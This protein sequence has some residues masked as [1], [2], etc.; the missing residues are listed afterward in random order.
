MFDDSTFSSVEDPFFKNIT[1]TVCVTRVSEDEAPEQL[2]GQY[3]LGD[4]EYIGSDNKIH[5]SFID[6][7]YK[8]SSSLDIK[9]VLVRNFA[10]ELTHMY[11]N[12]QRR[13]HGKE[14]MDQVANRNGYS[15]YIHRSE[16]DT[17][18]VKNLKQFLY[19]TN[20]Q[21]QNAFI[22][23]LMAELRP[24]AK[25]LQ[26]SRK[27]EDFLEGTQFLRDYNVVKGYVTTRYID[28]TVQIKENARKNMLNAFHEFFP[29]YRKP[30][31]TFRVQTFADLRKFIL[32]RWNRC[33]RKIKDRLGKII[34]DL[35]ESNSYIDYNVLDEKNLD[36]FW[37]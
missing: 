24:K 35:Y 15:K 18:S 2:Q 21:E 13:L 8:A 25:S 14:T 36:K 17:V 30:D 34:V 37:I 29:N 27:V 7:R 33:D 22:G 28:G 6:L 19:W 4:Q 11:E 16:S 12:Y 10:H 20:G 23:S 5:N 9:P 26:N 3:V 1:I 32:Q 31:G